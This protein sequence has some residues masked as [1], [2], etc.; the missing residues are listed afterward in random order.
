MMG[1][2]CLVQG[3]MLQPCGESSKIP[4][5]W[6]HALGPHAGI[7]VLLDHLLGQDTSQ[8]CI[9]KWYIEILRSLH[10]QCKEVT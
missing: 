3:L 7:S 1:S 2:K 4:A 5:A 8:E 6:P 9:Q 10:A